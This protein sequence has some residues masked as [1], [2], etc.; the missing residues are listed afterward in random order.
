MKVYTAEEIKKFESM[1]DKEIQDLN[2]EDFLY[3]YKTMKQHNY[4]KAS[5]TV[6][7][8]IFTIDDEK[9]EEDKS[10]KARLQTLM[11]KRG[12]HPFKNQWAIAGGFMDMNEDLDTAVKRE[13][14]EET[15]LENVYTEQLYTWSE[16][17]RDPRMRVISSSYMALLPKHQMAN[18]VAGD[19]AID[20]DWFDISSEILDHN[21]QLISETKVVETLKVNLVLESETNQASTV[22]KVINTTEGTISNQTIE[23]VER[24]GIAF[25]HSKILYTALERLRGKV[26]YTNIVF[27]LMPKKFTLVELQSAYETI[28]GR[29]ISK[30]T[31]RRH[32]Q[33]MVVPL[34]EIDD[35]SKTRPAQLY[36]YNILWKHSTTY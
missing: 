15:G 31:F 21:V 22:L 29:T 28:L 20:V 17:E 12:G 24:N 10:A 11:I 34:D 7:M 19:D 25:D 18:A 26:D 3:V 13:L 1:T 9:R 32:V 16:V 14:K 33:N 30:A 5:N 2:E 36:K 27:N 35:A 8:V 23:I 4:E 6:D